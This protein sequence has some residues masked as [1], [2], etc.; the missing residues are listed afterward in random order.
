MGQK[1]V[2]KT[3]AQKVRFRGGFWLGT[4]IKSA[5]SKTSKSRVELTHRDDIKCFVEFIDVDEGRV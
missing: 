3:E 2:I 4:I 5:A 1:N